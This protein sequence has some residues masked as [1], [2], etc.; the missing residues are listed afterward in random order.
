MSASNKKRTHATMVESNV[1]PSKQPDINTSDTTSTRLQLPSTINNISPILYYQPPTM[2]ANNRKRTHS[3]MLGGNEDNNK[4]SDADD[5]YKQAP[6]ADAA[7]SKPQ[8]EDARDEEA[9]GTDQV[10]IEGDRVPADIS[11]S[12]VA[13][14]SDTTGTHSTPHNVDSPPYNISGQTRNTND[15][16]Q[17]APSRATTDG[18]QVDK[19][20]AHSYTSSPW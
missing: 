1:S 7:T 19:A 4:P 17:E 18:P 16:K 9:K 15:S 5:N 13:D 6:N 20:E 12:T 10:S 11:H 8:E 14:P 3:T 2:C